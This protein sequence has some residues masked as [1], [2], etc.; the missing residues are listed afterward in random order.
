[1]KRVTIYARVSTREQNV[2]RQLIDL[3]HYAQSRTTPKN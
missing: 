3:L 2:D 1:M